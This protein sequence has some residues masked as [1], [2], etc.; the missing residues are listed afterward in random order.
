[1]AVFLNLSFLPFLG[2]LNIYIN[3]PL[4]VIFFIT[5]FY[6]FDIALFNGLIVGLVLDLYASSF[7]GFFILIFVVEVYFIYFLKNNLL[8]GKSLFSLAF[9]SL[10]SVLLWYILYV[11]FALPLAQT[12]NLGLYLKRFGVPFIWQN[13]LHIIVLLLSVFLSHNTKVKL[14]GEL[15]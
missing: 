12:F 11:T 9:C 1:M 8:R 6:N 5:F 13:I 4:L 15:R 10:A 7:F 2:N 3:L 14:K